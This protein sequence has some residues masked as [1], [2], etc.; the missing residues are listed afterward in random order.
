MNI[1]KQVTLATTLTLLLS[2]NILPSD[3]IVPRT[4]NATAAKI[5]FID[6]E[7]LRDHDEEYA[8]RK[9]ELQEDINK[10][11]KKFEELEK[12]QRGLQAKLKSDDISDDAKQKI[13][14]EMAELQQKAQIDAN[15]AQQTIAKRSE[16]LDKDLFNRIK[17]TAGEVS[18]KLDFDAVEPAFI[19]NNANL[20]LT[21][22]VADALNEKYKARKKPAVAPAAK[23]A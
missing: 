10:L 13:A 14:M 21:T 23:A 7:K 20:D 19:V 5:A 4:S 8:A 22:K 16:E 2:A 9:D 3:T 11:R 18:R 15:N 6:I 12:K 1:S 17:K